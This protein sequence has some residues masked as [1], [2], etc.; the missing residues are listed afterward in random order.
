M[1]ASL[2]QCT[3]LKSAEGYLLM[4]QPGSRRLHH[5]VLPGGHSLLL[6]H[7]AMHPVTVR[8]PLPSICHGLGSR[9]WL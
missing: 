8:V 5:P 1:G 2:L 7:G 4:S 9:W 3:A 6:S